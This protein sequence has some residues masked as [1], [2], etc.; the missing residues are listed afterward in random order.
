M[1]NE[2]KPACEPMTVEQIRE[3]IRRIVVANWPDART[4]VLTMRDGES[5][6]IGRE[7]AAIDERD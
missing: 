1:S 4:F 7:S 3:A 2:K 6:V 5:R